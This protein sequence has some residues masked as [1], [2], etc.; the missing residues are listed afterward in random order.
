MEYIL[1]NKPII[2]NNN[3][4]N[5]YF[6]CFNILSNNINVSKYYN[7]LNKCEDYHINNLLDFINIKW[8]K[9]LYLI[10]NEYTKNKYKNKEFVKNIDFNKTINK[11]INN[12]RVLAVF[13]INCIH[14][15]FN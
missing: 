1:T 4:Y 2:I 14:R 9:M 13:I 3:T 15:F 11:F 7:I 10:N 6:D 12:D 5:R 8:S